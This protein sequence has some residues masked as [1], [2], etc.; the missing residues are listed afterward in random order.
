MALL[1]L[2]RALLPKLPEP[3]TLS[4]FSS[5]PSQNFVWGLLLTL[6][7]V[8]LGIAAFLP[9]TPDEAYYWFWSRHLQ[10]GYVD[11]PAMVALWIRAGTELFGET[12]LGVRFM[13]VLAALVGSCALWAGVQKLLPC[14]HNAG[15]QAVLLLNATLMFG[16][17]MCLMTP[18]TPQMFFA[19][20]LIWTLAHALTATGPHKGVGWWIATGV[21]LGA[22]MEAKYT[23]LLLGLGLAG[24]VL[25]RGLWRQLGPWLGALTAGLCCLPMLLWNAHHQWAGFLKQGGRLGHWQPAH[26]LQYLGELLAGQI[27]LMTPVVA[28][29]CLAGCWRARRE[30]PLLLWLIVPGSA[31]FIFHA[32]H[33]GR[34]QANWPCVLYPAFAV[35]GAL[36][37][38][39]LRLAVWTGMALEG[40]VVLQGVFHV[41]PLTAHQDPSLRLTAGWQ[42]LTQAVQQEARRSGSQAIAVPDYAL[43]AILGFYSIR[44]PGALPILGEDTRWATL[45]GLHNVENLGPV[46]EIE[47]AR[48]SAQSGAHLVERKAGLGEQGR[49]VRGYRVTLTHLGQGWELT[50]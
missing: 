15:T 32:L 24:Y 20:V 7:L 16:V 31:V 41:L 39:H 21:C 34:V 30:M 26:A 1:S 4:S 11:H 48:G 49:N 3:E 19:A 50:E 33:A 13:G 17:G 42:S 23:V 2:R 36:Y 9:L 43:A 18:D 25:Q 10:G 46:A 40:L 45:H 35:A 14:G 27:G 6:F 29:C 8:R 44:I 28:F 47:E 5:S 12:A 38:R 37:G 22:G